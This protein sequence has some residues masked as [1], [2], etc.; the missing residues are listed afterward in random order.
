MKTYL[1]LRITFGLISAGLLITLLFK[2]TKVPGGMILSGLFLGVIV[3]VG[4][5]LGCLILTGIL[6]FFFKQSSFLTIFSITTSISFL[7][8]HYQLY[9]PTLTIKVPNNY[10]GEVNLVLSNVKDNL[11]TVDSNGI[12]YLNKWTFE[13]TYAK[14]IVI[15]EDGKNLDK[16]LIGFDQSGFFGY[17]KSCCINGQQIENKNFEIVPDSLFGQKQYYSKDLTTLV[18]RKLVHLSH[19]DEHTIIDS[20]TVKIESEKK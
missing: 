4:I 20:L 5:V 3:I 7:A 13:K 17:G 19:L 1:K 18:D 2:L 9:S 8:F 12:A 16:N 14:P 11:L 6:K 10:I 15:Q